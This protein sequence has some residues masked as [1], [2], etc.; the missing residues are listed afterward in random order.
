[1]IIKA[2]GAEPT[3][4]EQILSRHEEEWT[5]QLNL[6]RPILYLSGEGDIPMRQE[7][8]IKGKLRSESLQIPISSSAEGGTYSKSATIRLTVPPN[9]LL[10]NAD[11]TS[12]IAKEASEKDH[13]IWTWDLTNLEVGKW[14]RKFLTV[15]TA[16]GA[17]IG[18]TEIFRAYRNE[19]FAGLGITNTIFDFRFHEAFSKN[20]AWNLGYRSFLS[21]S[22]QEPSFSILALSAEYRFTPGL[23]LKTPSHALTLSYNDFISDAFKV[24]AVSVGGYLMYSAP[25]KWSKIYDWTVVRLNVPFSSTAN[26]GF[27]INLS[28]A[29]EVVLK[30]LAGEWSWEFGTRY[31]S[32]SF[33]NTTSNSVVMTRWSLIA[34]MST[35]F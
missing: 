32:Y 21:T 25:E 1:M 13:D 35:L 10:Q 7:F 6:D 24:G 30:K 29:T 12:V 33:T 4:E 15:D 19:L 31:E 20:W 16:D 9:V 2:K 34:G 8:L 5:A 26:N 28:S 23:Y 11:K 3:N 18:S 17:L 22:P 14:N 27:N